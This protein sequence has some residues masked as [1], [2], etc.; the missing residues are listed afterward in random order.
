M[1]QE[2]EMSLLGELTYFLR[3]QVQL[4]TYGI[5][6]S[7]EK[8]LKQIMKNYG[9]GDCKPVSTQMVIGCNISYHDDSPMVNQPEY[10]SMIGSLLYITRTRPDTYSWDC[11]MIRSYSKR[12]LPSG[13][14][15]NFQ[16]STRDSRF[17]SM[18]S[19]EC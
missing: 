10:I 15:N 12:I 11:W 19:K 5:F 4:A 1:Q 6:L 13:C 17:W 2:F 9:M 14:K 16:V 3:L 8:Y 18:V 7:Q